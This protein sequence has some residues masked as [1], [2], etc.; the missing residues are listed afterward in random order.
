MRKA[1]PHELASYRLFH[2]HLNPSLVRAVCPDIKTIVLLRSPGERLLSA[3]HYWSQGGHAL[4][5]QGKTPD[6]WRAE[7]MQ[8][9]FIGFLTNPRFRSAVF[10]VQARLL[11]GAEF[12]PTPA[13]RAMAF[14]HEDETDERIASLALQEIDKA[15]FVGV[16]E[17]LPALAEHVAR[18]HGW[19][20][21]REIPHAKRALGRPALDAM[22]V[23]AG[24]VQAVTGADELVYGAVLDR[25]NH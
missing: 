25:V 20:T 16:T 8:T 22:G 9:D 23:A 4:K 13:T 18:Q 19:A 12:G 17:K 10:N 5:A 2:G 6:T 15:Q 21:P 1:D 14:G 7:L 3:F 24:A 11:A